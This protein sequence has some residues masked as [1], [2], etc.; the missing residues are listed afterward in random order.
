MNDRFIFTTAKK[1]RRTME[2]KF[3][4]TNAR[5]LLASLEQC[6]ETCTET[7]MHSLKEGG[8][9][10]KIE[11]IRI[12]LDCSEI[13]QVAV[14]FFLRDS[15]YAG[16]IIEL[17]AD[18]CEECAQSCETF[19]GHEHMKNCAMVCRTCAEDCRGAIEYGEEDIEMV[20]E[21]DK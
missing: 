14:N 15:D 12:L 17:C 3:D 1:T 7:V 11:H 10:A 18:I 6:Q 20:E 5:E 19:D 8:D 9:Y 13:C 2:D 16:N 21:E 4:E